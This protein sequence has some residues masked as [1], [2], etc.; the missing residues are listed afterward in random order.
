MK[1]SILCTGDDTRDKLNHILSPHC[2]L[3]THKIYNCNVNADIYHMEKILDEIRR[4][5]KTMRYILQHGTY[6]IHINKKGEKK[7]TKK[8]TK[9][10]LL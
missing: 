1:L 7:I 8:A 3:S 9:M 2:Q 6:R 5:D 10:I 4:T